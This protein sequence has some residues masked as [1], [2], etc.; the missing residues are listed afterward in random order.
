MRFADKSSEHESV[1][2]GERTEIREEASLQPEA[3]EQEY[4]AASESTDAI[5]ADAEPATSGA[6]AAADQDIA[7]TSETT[8]EVVQRGGSHAASNFDRQN[9]VF[10]AN[11]P[12]SV[13]NDDLRDTFSTVGEVAS[14][15]LV[16][17][18]TQRSRGFGFVSMA[19]P[20]GARQAVAD[21]HETML[22]G[23]SLVVRM[24]EHRDGNRNMRQSRSS[25]PVGAS[26]PTKTLYVGGLNRNMTD[27][28]LNGE[29]PLP[30]RC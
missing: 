25:R 24:S 2:D 17:D 21:L 6:S 15:R 20:E 30:R 7:A 23:R 9:Q 14:A 22:Q 19:S 1:L 12:W 16:L 11:L 8:D 28:D 27:S 13:T 26:S 4:A 18:G 10:V 3:A 5:P 29:S